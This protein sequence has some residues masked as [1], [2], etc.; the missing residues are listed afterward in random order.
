MPSVPSAMS[1]SEHV[2]GLARCGQAVLR[3]S[4]SFASGANGLMTADASV[5][6]HS[7]QRKTMLISIN[8]HK[9]TASPALSA[10]LL[11]DRPGSRVLPDRERIRVAGVRGWSSADRPI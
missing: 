6:G 7:R 3:L 11:I 4:G 9:V 5:A 8:N 2:H 1:M 10:A